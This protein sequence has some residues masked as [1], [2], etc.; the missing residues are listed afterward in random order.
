[1]YSFLCTSETLPLSNEKFWQQ[2]QQSRIK[3]SKRRLEKIKSL[4][5]EMSFGGSKSRFK[6]LG[7]GYT[8]TNLCPEHG[9]AKPEH[10]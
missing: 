5:N 9:A 8:M 3:R 4:R 6:D 1:M 7:W 2:M 10:K